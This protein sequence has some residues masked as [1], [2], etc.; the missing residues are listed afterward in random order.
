MLT[1]Y[2][3]KIKNCL[4]ADDEKGRIIFDNESNITI[5]W[6]TYDKVQQILYNGSGNTIDFVYNRAKILVC[7]TVLQR[8][9][10]GSVLQRSRLF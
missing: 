8:G 10:V 7:G 1:Q 4:K 2:T 5:T 9:N 3:P 6:N